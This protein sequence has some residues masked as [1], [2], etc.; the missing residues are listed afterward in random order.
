MRVM[1]IPISQDCVIIK[2]KQVNRIVVEAAPCP[3][4]ISIPSFFLVMRFYLDS[5]PSG[6]KIASLSVPAVSN[7]I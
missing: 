4:I 2:I 6:G 7:S 1:I 5:W 3:P